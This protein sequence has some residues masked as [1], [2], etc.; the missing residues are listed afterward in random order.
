MICNQETFH[1][2]ILLYQAKSSKIRMIHNLPIANVAF[3]NRF[4]RLY[5][6]LH[7]DWQHSLRSL[8]IRVQLEE[9]VKIL[10]W[11]VLHWSHLQSA[12]RQIEPHQSL[13]PWSSQSCNVIR[14]ICVLG[15]RVSLPQKICTHFTLFMGL[16]II[17]ICL[18]VYENCY[19]IQVVNHVTFHSLKYCILFLR[20][21]KWLFFSLSVS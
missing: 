5:T 17:N 19:F 6:L 10:H 4:T 11:V 9:S 1:I 2:H 3:F 14:K 12:W 21:M 13:W 8:S 7:N 20:L 15:V 16:M 18:H